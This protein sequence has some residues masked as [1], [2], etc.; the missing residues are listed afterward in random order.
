MGYAL[1][2]PIFFAGIGLRVD[3]LTHFDLFLVLL[4]SILGVGSR[5]LGAWLGAAMT[6]LPRDDR[7]TIGVSH[8]PGGAMEVI[9]AVLALQFGLITQP[10]FVAI[11]FGAVFSSVILGPWMSYSVS[12]R[13]E[14]SLLEYFTRASIIPDLKATTQERALEELSQLAAAQDHTLRAEDIYAAVLQRENEMGTALEERLAVP[15]ARFKNLDRPVIVFG[16]SRTGI[17]WNSPDGELTRFIFLVLAPERNDDQVQVLASI[18]R[19]MNQEEVRE[20]ALRAEGA[21]A[22]W[23]IL[24]KAFGTQRVARSASRRRKLRSRA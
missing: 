15:H 9:V 2:V 7:A 4:I 20:Q 21:D 23:S 11:V 3:F 10:V 14:V 8:T 24:R 12:K 19:T 17:D 16:R 6:R 22:L 13:R 18:V 1:F 5:Y